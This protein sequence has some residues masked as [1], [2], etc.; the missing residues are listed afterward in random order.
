MSRLQT[1]SMQAVHSYRIAAVTHTRSL[2]IAADAVPRAVSTIPAA[3]GAV[4]ATIAGSA[5]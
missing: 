4:H 3:E 1:H 5:G 2:D